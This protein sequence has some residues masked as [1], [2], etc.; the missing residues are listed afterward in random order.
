MLTG[1]AARSA[2][3]KRAEIRQR[4]EEHEDYTDSVSLAAQ[5]FASLAFL[6]LLCLFASVFWFVLT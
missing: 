5:C 6:V 2:D 1:A 4:M 3:R